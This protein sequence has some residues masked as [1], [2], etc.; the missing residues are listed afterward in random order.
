MTNQPRFD[1]DISLK[2]EGKTW[3]AKDIVSLEPMMPWSKR[4]IQGKMATFLFAFLVVSMVFIAIVTCSEFILLPDLIR[5]YI[6]ML[7]II[8]ISFIWFAFSTGGQENTFTLA[9]NT[10]SSVLFS[11][12]I[13]AMILTDLSLFFGCRYC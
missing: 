2:D 6:L 9:R 5:I 10:F 8:I 12:P 11:S 1:E 3:L 13:M 7:A 4:P